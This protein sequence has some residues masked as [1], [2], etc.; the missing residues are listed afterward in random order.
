MWTH[1]RAAWLSGFRSHSFRGLF[2]LSVLGMAGAVIAANFSGRQ[3]ATVALDVGISALRLTSVLMVL[4]WTQEL[5]GKEI[6]RKTVF[7][8]LTY[9][10]PR[11]SYILGRFFGIAAL[12]AACVFIQTLVVY[13]V[14]RFAMRDYTQAAPIYL[15]YLPWVALY[16][17]FDILVVAAFTTFIACLSTTPMLPLVLGAG[18]AIAARSLGPALDFLAQRDQVNQQL[19]AHVAPILNIVRWCM[20]DLS[21]LDI[22]P[23]TLYGQIPDV[24]SLLWPPLTALCYTVVMLIA[25]VRYFERRE[26]S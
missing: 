21:R 14:V 15:Q 4:F 17:Y 19:A 20:P 25:A 26:L 3:P 2:L 7:F 11:A 1:F 22:R 12:A 16:C 18:F 24:P 6:E 5:L 13:G 10:V 23:L 9:P 8:A